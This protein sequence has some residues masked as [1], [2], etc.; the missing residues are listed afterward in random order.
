MICLLMCLETL[1]FLPSR[2]PSQSRHLLLLADLAAKLALL[3]RS[4]AVPVGPSPAAAWFAAVL[5]LA[6]A[7]LLPAAA[8]PVI[9]A[10][11]ERPAARLVPATAALVFGSGAPSRPGSRDENTKD[12]IQ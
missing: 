5:A 9:A 6:A 11:V 2:S 7:P 1:C 12:Q 10:A 4:A 3:A 8:V